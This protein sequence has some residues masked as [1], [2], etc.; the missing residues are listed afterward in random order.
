MLYDRILKMK[1]IILEGLP[2][3]GKSTIAERIKGLDLENIVV[4]DELILPV[5]ST[6]S[7][8]TL[9]FMQNDE[10]KLIEKPNT[11]LLVDRGPIST[12]SYNQTK[13]I[14]DIDYNFDFNILNSWFKKFIPFYQRNDVIVLYLKSKHLNYNLRY[15][16]EKCPHGTKENQNL[17]EQITLYNCKKYVKNLVI[18]EYSYEEIDEV[19]SEIIDKFMCS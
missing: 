12:L 5:C 9:D 15:Y 3:V 19:I 1:V 7:A 17:M 6:E 13:N 10:K 18:R 14:V 4:S 8:T 11:H 16:D 2:K